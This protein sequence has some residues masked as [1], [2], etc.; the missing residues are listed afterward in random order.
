MRWG[1]SG[2]AYTYNRSGTTWTERY[3]VVASDGEVGDRRR[4]SSVR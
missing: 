3:K 1:T 4:E 2:S